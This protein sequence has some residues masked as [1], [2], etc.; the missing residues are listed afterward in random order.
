MLLLAFA[1]HLSLALHASTWTSP[2]DNSTKQGKM[3][4][5]LAT[6]PACGGNFNVVS[7]Q[8]QEG[9]G[10]GSVAFVYIASQ[11]LLMEKQL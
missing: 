7:H 2:C 10:L 5:H 4:P 3:L 8:G 11:K 1:T 9:L 6:V